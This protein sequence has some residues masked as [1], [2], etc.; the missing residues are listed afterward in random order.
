ML[1]IIGNRTNTL[2]RGNNLTL[3]GF[4]AR[5]LLVDY[6]QAAF[7][8][9]HTAVVTEEDAALAAW[10]TDYAEKTEEGQRVLALLHHV[11]NMLGIG[12]TMGN[13]IARV[14][15]QERVLRAMVENASRRDD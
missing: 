3:A 4:H 14:D 7:A 1:E 12:P 13:L 8:A 11:F 2:A 15:E 10:A 6:I 5:V 9:H